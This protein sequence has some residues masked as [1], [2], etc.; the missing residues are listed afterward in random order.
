M[1]APDRRGGVRVRAHGQPLSSVRHATRGRLAL[2]HARKNGGVVLAVAQHAAGRDWTELAGLFLRGS[3][4]CKA[5]TRGA[6]VRG[7][8]SGRR[9][10]GP[11]AV[12]LGL[13][14]REIPCRSW[15]AP[16]DPDRRP[17]RR[18]HAAAGLAPGARRAA[19]RINV[20][21]DSQS[22]RHG[23]AACIRRVDRSCRV[24]PRPRPATSTERAA[25][26]ACR[27]AR[28][29]NQWSVLGDTGGTAPLAKMEHEC[30][31]P[32]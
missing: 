1:V 11:A 13:V 7:A 8:Q 27:R 25:S 23:R 21:S 5:R 31:E 14:E 4:G 30:G 19:S 29:A 22:D 20:A 24:P 6:A 9:R 16:K 18:W 12:G 15:S 2:A 28:I 3:D 17:T 26:G 10:S 32:F